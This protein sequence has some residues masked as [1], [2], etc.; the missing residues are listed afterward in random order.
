MP[1][2]AKFVKDLL[3]KKRYVQHETVNLTHRVGAIIASTT[4][5]KKGDP[6]AF[7]IPCNIGLHAFARALCDNGASI[8]LMPLAIFKQYGLGTL[9]P[10]FMRLQMA[11]RSIK[12]PIRVIDDVL[13]QRYSIILGKTVSCYGRKLMDYEKNE[14]KFRVND[15]E[16]TFQASKGMKFSSTYESISVIDSFDG[17]DD[18]VEY[19]MEEESLG[20]AL[21]V[22]LINF[23]DCDMEGYV[24]TINALEGL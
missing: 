5:Q 11:G 23:E 14:I 24:E 17:I 9:R 22:A 3:T 21:A 4:V 10:T 20:E 16:V 18:A 7:S 2:F 6:G 19:K 13:V 12:K 8:N 15:E 1:E